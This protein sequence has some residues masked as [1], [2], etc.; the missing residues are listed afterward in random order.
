VVD[1][2]LDSTSRELSAKVLHAR[3]KGREIPMIDPQLS[4]K[5]AVVTGANNPRGIGAAIA[6]ALAVQGVA[7]YVTYHRQEISAETA[8]EARKGVPGEALYRWLNAESAEEVIEEVRAA[9]GLVEGWEVDL[10]DPA[11]CAEV[12]D[13]A[14]RALGPVEILVNNAAFCMPDSFLP[15]EL[16]EGK[17]SAGGIPISPF[18]ITGH[19]RHFHVN[20]RAPALLI[21]EF[22]SRHI[23]RGARWGRI[24]NVSTDGASC[25]PTEV[26]YGGSKYA[27]ESLTRSAAVELGAYGITVNVVS[28][29]PI[30]TGYIAPQP[31]ASIVRSIPLGRLGE[32]M[33]VADVVV[34]L[35]SE[36]ARW[37]TGQLLYVGGGHAMHS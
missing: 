15:G 19:D 25:F 13:R 14:E 3:C 35:A 31:E 6:R 32:P 9:G 10:A 21:R 17:P 33:D 36:Q 5:V 28:P 16:A 8:E 37:L 34:F 23:A 20:V 4:G 11:T 30:Q 18:S 22:A 24:I 1:A 27:L 26:S 29:G 2:T 12:F 7:V